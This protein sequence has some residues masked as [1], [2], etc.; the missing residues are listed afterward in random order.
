MP[1]N[2]VCITFCVIA[3]SVF[4]GPPIQIGVDGT[5]HFAVV[6]LPAFCVSCLLRQALESETAGIA[7]AILVVFCLLAWYWALVSRQLPRIKS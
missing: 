2:H 6:F 7:L 4:R 5:L 1:I 3:V